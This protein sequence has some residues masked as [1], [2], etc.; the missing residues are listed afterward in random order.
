[1]RVATDPGLTFLWGVDTRSFSTVLLACLVLVPA[2]AAPQAFTR[3][4]AL[5]SARRVDADASLP[6]DILPEGVTAHEDLVYA[7][8]AE[9]VELKLDVYQ[10]AGDGPFPAVI[11]VHGGGWESGDR[12]M[13]R[14]LA[15]RLAA[16]GFVAVPVSYRLGSAGR[17][18]H[19][20]H[21]LKAAVRWL[22]AHAREH[23]IDPEVIGAVGGSAGGHLVALLGAT[24]ATAAF[25]GD[26]PHRDVSSSVQAVVDL[27]G[28]VDFTGPEL[29][30][31]QKEKPSAPTRFLGATFAENPHVW[32]E[33]SPLTH[34]GLR[35]APTLFINS[36]APTPILPGREE[37]SR[38]LTMMGIDSE[39]LTMEGSPHVFWL[40]EPW[41]EPAVAEI[42]RFL[43]KHLVRGERVPAAA[44][45]S[46][47]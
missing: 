33:A 35:S 31:Q 46:S 10:P 26:G 39:V 47:D 43:E 13:E 16:E 6:P 44:R 42:V 41:F 2:A 28:L 18:P 15:K 7:T 29:L 21:D 14:P 37:M 45:L 23:A 36:S 27:D 34:L 25:E 1:M 32:R 5:E 40:V 19:A 20:L 24:N 12:T 17:F 4:S 9:G 22:R 11:V 30:A 38:R 8:P 3:E